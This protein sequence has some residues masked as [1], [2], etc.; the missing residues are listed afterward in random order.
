ML[1]KRIIFC[2]FWLSLPVFAQLD[3]LFQISTLDALMG[4]AF[5]GETTIG[6]LGRHGDFGIGTFNAMDGEMIVLDGA[7]YRI[8]G[9]GGVKEAGMLDKSPFAA[10][11]FFEA[12][13]KI[14]PDSSMT[15][16][17]LYSFLDARIP[18]P[19]LFYAVKVHGTFR[20]VKTRSV[21]RQKKPYP[22]LVEVIKTQPV[23]D[24]EEVEGILAGFRCPAYMKGI[25]FPGYHLHFLARDKRGGGHVLNFITDSVTVEIDRTDQFFL[26]LPDDGTFFKMDL[27]GDRGAEIKQVER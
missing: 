16:S 24:F 12:D 27:S 14:R 5:D 17:G 23:F 19:N 3:V 15:M 18:T 20:T 22:S 26:N 8:D 13:Q 11:T 1:K 21:P 4:G 9:T 7:F 25:Q 10:V 2:I 6:E